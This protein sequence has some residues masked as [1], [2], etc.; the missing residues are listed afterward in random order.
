MDTLILWKL[1]VSILAVVGLSM[2]AERVSARLAGI[3]SGYPLGSAIALFFIGV[4]QGS[5]FAAE[6]AV[7]TLAG[8][9]ASLVLTYCYYH[10]SR[11]L[12]RWHLPAAIVAGL[13]GFL[14]AAMMIQ[15]VPQHLSFLWSD[16]VTATGLFSGD[17]LSNQLDNNQ[18]GT[19]FNNEQLTS[20]LLGA[21]LLTVLSILLFSRLFGAIDNVALTGQVSI[22]RKVLLVR[23]LMAAATVLLIT[24]IAGWVGPAWSGLLSAFPITLFPFMLILHYSYGKGVVYTVIKNYPMGL[25]SLLCYAVTVSFSYRYWGIGWGTAA[26]FAVATLYLAGLYLWLNRRQQL[27]G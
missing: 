12:D 20:G 11:R 2:V 7:H 4:E 18:F 27:D 17:Q 13:A 1:L 14:V 26:G 22:S 5:A 10:A 3:L 9:S 21:G 25:G 24:G 16:G 23:A 8:F 15:E 6:A 19:Q